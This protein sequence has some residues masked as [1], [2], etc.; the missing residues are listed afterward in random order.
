MEFQLLDS[1]ETIKAWKQENRSL[2]PEVEGG[3]RDEYK[4]HRGFVGQ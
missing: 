4:E 3:W 2:L 1:L